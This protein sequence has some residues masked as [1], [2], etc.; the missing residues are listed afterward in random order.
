MS[1][2]A[3]RTRLSALERQASIV[4]AATRVFARGGYSGATTSDIAR[5]A[6]VNEALLFRHFGSKQGLFLAC[7]DA[8]WQRVLESCEEG[9]AEL[10][11][12]RH[13]RVPGR[14]F[15]H[16]MRSEPDPV[17]LWIRGL[18]ETTGVAAIDGH[19]DARITEVHE[20]VA[21]AVERSIAAGGTLPGR[22][23]RSEAWTI[24]SLGLLG[25]SLGMRGV[26]PEAEFER[27]ISAHREWL[28]GSA[29]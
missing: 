7:V 6:V 29:E 19:L 21:A 2:A 8:A 5:E 4:E 17:R 27:A 25:S 11:E 13:W 9:F 22:D 1:E 28:T 18:V 16:L 20:F 26:V 23:A 3:G 14:S 12:E 15:L 10:P 24:I